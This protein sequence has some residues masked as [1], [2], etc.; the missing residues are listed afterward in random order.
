MRIYLFLILLIIAACST[1]TQYVPET[2]N[3]GFSDKT[4][5]N[6]LRVASFQGNAKT[7][8]ETAE[9]YAKFRAME[10][11]HELGRRYTHLLL[12]KDKTFSKI[13][14]TSSTTPNYYYGMAPYYGRYGGYGMAYSTPTTTTSSESSTFPFYEVYFEC[15]EEP[16]DARISFIDLSSSQMDKL[17]SDLKGAIQVNEVLSDSPNIGKLQKADIVYKVAG[18]RVTTIIEAYHAARKSKNQSV[19]V[20]FF[21]DGMKKQTLVSFKNV[22]ELVEQSQNEIIK[23]ACKLDDLKNKN[24]LCKK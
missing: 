5:E 4:I 8:K 7:K 23:E 16:V 20:E 11:C 24:D 19:M 14:Q 12:V 9:L 2:K 15:V 1:P 21:R 10:V 13:T 17:V 22:A 3:K 6:D 18:E